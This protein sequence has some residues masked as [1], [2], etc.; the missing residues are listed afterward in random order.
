MTLHLFL[1]LC[2]YRFCLFCQYW[3]WWYHKHTLLTDVRAQMWH[4]WTCLIAQL[5]IM[6]TLSTIWLSLAYF[7]TKAFNSVCIHVLKLFFNIWVTA[8]PPWSSLVPGFIKLSIWSTWCFSVICPHSQGSF[9]VG[10]LDR[11]TGENVWAFEPVADNHASCTSC[12][13]Q[14]DMVASQFVERACCPLPRNSH[15]HGLSD[16]RLFPPITDSV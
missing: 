1:G 7:S 13:F 2:F 15:S 5:F 12:L 9:L 8:W 10:K 11:D 3:M 4:I 6:N 16:P 14:G